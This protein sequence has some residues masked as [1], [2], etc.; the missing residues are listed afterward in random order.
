[1]PKGDLSVPANPKLYAS[2]REKLKREM[3]WPSAY[4]SGALVRLYKAKGG[5]YRR[6]KPHELKAK[7]E[8]GK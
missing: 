6:G 3:P 8:G 7:A 5:K 1:M 4:A 2:I